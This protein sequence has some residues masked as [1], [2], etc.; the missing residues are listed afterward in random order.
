M[1]AL[2][3][4]FVLVVQKDVAERIQARLFLSQLQRQLVTAQTYAMT[5][6]EDT[7]IWLDMGHAYSTVPESGGVRVPDAIQVS[8]YRYVFSGKSGQLKMY[9]QVVVTT[10]QKLYTVRV[11]FGKGVF[12]IE[13]VFK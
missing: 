7:Q 1:V 2:F 9:Q 8:P 10:T 4:L 5:S 13:E 11:Q 6:G 12:W 3:G